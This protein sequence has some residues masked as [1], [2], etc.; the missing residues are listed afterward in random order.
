VSPGAPA[1]GLKLVITGDPMA[2]P[3]VTTTQIAAC[4][5]AA[6]EIIL[7]RVQ[8]CSSHPHSAQAFTEPIS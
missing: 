2:S 6:F 1:L 4:T 8:P 7:N 5:N 3:I